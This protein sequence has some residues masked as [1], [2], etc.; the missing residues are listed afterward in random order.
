MAATQAT[1]LFIIGLL[2]DAALYAY[3]ALLVENAIRRRR[4]L[5]N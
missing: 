4:R 5:S 3:L 2:V 1:P